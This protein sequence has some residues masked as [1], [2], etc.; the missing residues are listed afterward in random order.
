M[1]ILLKIIHVMIIIKVCDLKIRYN[2]DICNIHTIP[3]LSTALNNPHLL[4][5]ELGLWILIIVSVSAI[6]VLISLIVC[7]KCGRRRSQKPNSDHLKGND[8]NFSIPIQTFL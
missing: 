5:L 1:I 4:F 8:G 3:Q 7:W 6:L 2:Y